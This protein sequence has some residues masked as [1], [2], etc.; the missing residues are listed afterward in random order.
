MNGG[1]GHAAATIVVVHE[2]LAVL[3]LIEQALRA[4]GRR[5]LTTSNALEALDV[6]RR[7]KIDLLVLEPPD[8]RAAREFARDIRT[9]QPQLRVVYLLAKPLS[10]SE[11]TAEVARKIGRSPS[12]D[13]SEHGWLNTP[14]ARAWRRR[15][16]HTT[17][18]SASA[19]E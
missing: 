7:V 18:R 19:P 3:E 13:R 1:N 9:V 14:L 6:V 10:L 2:S 15:S 17:S 11:L 12:C 5:V 16:A 8:C 4:P